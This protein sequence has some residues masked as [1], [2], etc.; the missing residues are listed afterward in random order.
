MGAG[1]TRVSLALH[2][3]ENDVGE[4]R[5]TLRLLEGFGERV[6][7]FGL[8]ATSVFLEKVLV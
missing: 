1:L 7:R 2:F 8:V 5:V 3:T 4:R 6:R